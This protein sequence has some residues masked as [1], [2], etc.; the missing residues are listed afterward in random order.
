[1]IEERNLEIKT[2]RE[3]LLVY[4]LNV[5]KWITRVLKKYKEYVY[6]VILG[7]YVIMLLKIIKLSVNYILY[8]KICKL[9]YYVVKIG[10][11]CIC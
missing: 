7:Y 9:L 10:L 3:K 4:N 11:K 2:V 1:V 5:W 8:F 6:I